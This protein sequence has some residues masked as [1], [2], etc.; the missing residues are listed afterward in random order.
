MSAG[1]PRTAR[2]PRPVTRLRVLRVD[3]LTPHMR[4]IHAGG[5]GFAGFRT[6]AFTDKYVKLLFAP[7]GVTIPDPCDLAALRRELPPDQVPVTRTYTVRSVDPKAG[8]L[9]I[10]FVLHGDEGIAGP[11]AKRAQPG[12]ELI[13][14]GPGGAYAPSAAADWHLMAGDEAA[15]PAIGAAIEAAPDGSRVRA[16]IEVDSPAERQSFSSKADVDI[17]WLYRDGAPAGDVTRLVEAVKSAPWLD[18]SPQ[19]FVH[20]ESGVMAGLRRWLLNDRE[21]RP[22]MLSISGYWRTGL[23]E[24][25]FRKWKAEQRAAEVGSPRP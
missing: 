16:V 17:T 1:S 7:P 10:D 5:P 25:D 24:E 13:F 14:T 12:D 20:G 18:G 2:P 8:E 6:N 19:V 23:V 9:A 4:R 3:D 11:C 15:L 21:V 22:D